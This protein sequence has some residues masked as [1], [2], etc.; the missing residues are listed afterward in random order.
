MRLGPKHTSARLVRSRGRE[1]GIALSDK[2]IDFLI[3]RKLSHVNF[4]LYEHHTASLKLEEKQ[5]KQ[6]DQLPAH[7]Y[8]TLGWQFQCF[9]E[10][11]GLVV[12]P[13]EVAAIVTFWRR[14][15][16]GMR[17]KGCVDW[18]TA[19]TLWR[20]MLVDYEVRWSEWNPQLHLPPTMWD[21]QNHTQEI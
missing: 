14:E 3:K 9:Q 5:K 11:F 6:K 16:D 15:L 18:S 4:N 19:Y 8:T 21:W 10:L 20:N 12:G 17:V 1:L 7:S 13:T 2:Q